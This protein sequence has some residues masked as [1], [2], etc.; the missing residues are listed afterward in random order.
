VYKIFIETVGCPKNQEDSER[1]AGLLKKAGHVITMQPDEADVIVINTCGFIED[2]K[3]ESIDTIF[4][5]I[6]YKEYG[7]RLIVAGCLTQRY[8]D[9]L[10][11]ELPEAD[12]I[13]GVNDY[14]RLP[15]I[16]SDFFERNE[17]IPELSVPVYTNGEPDILT[18][19]R[20]ALTPRHSSYLKIAE[21]CSN[22]CAYCV[23][24]DIRGP[25][26]S[27]PEEQLIEEAG[28]LAAE[29]CKELILIAQ[30]LTS[31]GRDLYGK[32]ALSDS[33]RKLCE[34]DKTKNIEWI[35]LLYCYEERITDGLIQLMANEQRILKYIDIPLQHLN[36]RLLKSMR[37]SSSKESIQRTISDLRE[38]MPDIVLRTTFITGL[39]GET[40]KDF[41]ELYDFILETQFDRM[42]VF[43]YSPE[44][45]TDAA[46]MSGQVD[47][48]TAEQRRDSLMMLQQQISLKKNQNL[49]G[50]VQD[51][52]VDG[53]EEESSDTEP[54]GD[55]VFV[56]RT[57][58]DA[59]EIDNTV[60]FEAAPG[61]DIIG[62]IVK[63]RITDALDYDL[64]GVC[65]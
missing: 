53:P 3:R 64:V 4:N 41:E 10:A 22:K 8:P 65:E 7:K 47:R 56:G 57:R 36:D 58:G 27:V 44:E 26:R 59:P 51:V 62:T 46:L 2:A 38:A 1:I 35:R 60:V 6:P 30:D 34:N 15:K 45:G 63:V 9:E 13:L 37:R 55:R 40:E 29:G 49:I 17:T 42:G 54:E 52:I 14:K 33:L 19:P 25:Y 39:P 24:P 11:C 28:R 12:A 20:S 31:Y 5:Y 32:Y 23:I 50:T 43:V 16:I 18:G 48:E 61:D 21:G